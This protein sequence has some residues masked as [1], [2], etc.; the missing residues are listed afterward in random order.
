MTCA[1]AR[2]S[3]DEVRLSS[4]ELFIIAEVKIRGGSRGGLE[5]PEVS[6]TFDEEYNDAIL[7]RS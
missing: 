2:H 7:Q 3:H 6:V 1:E 4:Q 5:V